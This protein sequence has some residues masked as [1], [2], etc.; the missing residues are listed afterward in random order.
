MRLDERLE[1]V[2]GVPQQLLAEHQVVRPARLVDER[3]ALLVIE[4]HLEVGRQRR[5]VAELV[6]VLEGEVVQPVGLELLEEPDDRPR[7]LAGPG[8]RGDRREAAE[9]GQEDE[10][11]AAR[12]LDAT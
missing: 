5:V 10:A 12:E 1:L 4:G 2:P 9:D 3:P 8:L 6:D 7:I 11:P